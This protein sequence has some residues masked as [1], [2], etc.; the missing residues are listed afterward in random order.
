MESPNLELSVG[1]LAFSE[2]RVWLMA[3]ESKMAADGQR[4]PQTPLEAQGDADGLS[5]IGPVDLTRP[6]CMM[7]VV[8]ERMPRY[9]VGSG[10]AGVM[11]FFRVDA[12]GEIVSH[13]IAATAGAAEFAEA[14][15]RVVGRWRIERM[16]N[17]APDCRMES[18]ILQGVQFVRQ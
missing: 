17:S 9:P 2:A 16:E 14:V 4:V 10:V 15:E 8:A 5:E 1:Q 7:R 3:L 6:R 11:L 13:Q 18:N 12:N